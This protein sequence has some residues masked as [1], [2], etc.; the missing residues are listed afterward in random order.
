MA[1]RFNKCFL[2]FSPLHSEFSPRCRIIDKFSDYFSFNVCDKE[3]DNKYY[4]YQLDK[5]ILESLS[6]PSIAI[7]ASDTSIKNNVTTLISHTHMCNRPIT[8]T[9]HHAVYITST[10]AE[11]FA[12]R[13]SIKQVLNFDNVS[14]IIVITDSIYAARKIFE[15]FVHPYQV[16]LAAILSNLCSFFKHD[17]NNS[18]EFWE[19]PS[20]LKWHL[21]NEVNKET[22]TFNPTLL[23]PC[24]T[25]WDFSK[26]SES[27]VILKVWKMMF[28]ASDL[29][30]NQFLDLLDND[31]NIIELSYIKGGSWLKIFGHSNSLCMHATRA[32]TNHTPISEYRLRFF[33]REEFKCPCGLY[34]IESRRHI[35]HD[36]GRFNGYWNLRRDSLSHFVMFLETNLGTF[37]FSDSLV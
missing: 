18:I 16:Q 28:Q 30:G 25:L 29:K 1:N 10:E 14:K 33:P 31:N 9:I 2:S 5:M 15:L 24:K 4:A 3:K 7:I 20:H 19:C 23:Y 8:K 11:L 6:F 35:L 32:I 21:H 37:T 12:I 36:C 22:K 17:E 34:S 26:K 13:C 27:D